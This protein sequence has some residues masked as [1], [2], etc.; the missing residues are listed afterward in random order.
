MT[1]SSHDLQRYTISDG[2][3]VVEFNYSRPQSITRQEDYEKLDRKSETIKILREHSIPV[4]RGVV[5]DPGK[6][7]A[8]ELREHADHLGYP[9]VLKPDTGSFGQGVSTGLRNWNDLKSGYDRLIRELSPQ[10]II[11]E[12]HYVGDDYRLLVVG[13]R[14]VGAVR[15]VPAHVI[16]DGVSTIR[17]LIDA[18]NTLRK[19]NP[20]LASCLIKDNYEVQ[21]CLT[22]QDL[23]V[24]DIPGEGIHVT[25]RRVANA[26][27]GGDVVDVTDILPEKI[28]EAAVQAV[29]ALPRVVV[30]GV[31]VLYKADAETGENTFAIIE[32][33]S[34]PHIGVNMY[35]SVG[36]GRDVPHVLIDTLF[37]GT[38]RPTIPDV[39]TLR[40]NSGAV[41]GAIRSGATT[42]VTL[43]KIPAHGYP[44]R[45]RLQY[46]AQTTRSAADRLPQVAL[47]QLAHSRGVAGSVRRTES[48]EIE[49]SVAAPDKASADVI[50]RKVAEWSG[51]DPVSEV[52]WRGPV[53]TTFMVF[54]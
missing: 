17:G 31:D 50:A 44:Y 37:P 30:A 47:Q 34:R 32:V 51:A 23:K 11:L 5:L 6:V 28:L 4:P 3:R 7:S 42:K 53:S 45:R 24:E 13:D 1:F 43:P 48:G 49:L 19:K 22:D 39:R 35:P 54:Q 25:L 26:S 38:Y 29:R 46:N 9:I 2:Q 16:G 10:R 40:F 33:N 27:A 8:A 36:E 41:G 14:V 21:K 18:K 52:P 20:F 15:R 12:Q